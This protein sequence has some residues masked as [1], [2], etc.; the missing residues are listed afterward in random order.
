MTRIN[1]DMP[2]DALLGLL[3][4]YQELHR[5]AVR[6]IDVPASNRHVLKIIEA[7]N[8]LASTSPGRDAL[9][10][11]LTHPMAYMRLRAAQRVLEW[12][13]KMAIPVL[14]RLLFENLGEESTVDERIDIRTS[15]KD[16]LFMHFGIRSW[17]RNDL[18]EPLKTYGVD[19]PYRD[20]DKWR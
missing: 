18:I 10:K 8:A 5:Q 19:L 14:G 2:V 11:L 17:N 20:Y 6:R 3:F 1:S 16:S 13:S 4:K 15:A 7:G 9:E 12:D